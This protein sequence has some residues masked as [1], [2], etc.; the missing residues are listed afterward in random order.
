MG[1]TLTSVDSP[2]E[3]L[4]L[5]QHRTFMTIFMLPPKY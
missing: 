3:W 4:Q 2:T 1:Y 5:S